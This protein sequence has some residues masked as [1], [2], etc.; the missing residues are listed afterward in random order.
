MLY[1]CT[2]QNIEKITKIIE[3]EVNNYDESC[4][5]KYVGRHI[6]KQ[7]KLQMTKQCEIDIK[8]GQFT[9]EEK[10]KEKEK[11]ILNKVIGNIRMSFINHIG[12]EKIPIPIIQSKIIKLFATLRKKI[13]NLSIDSP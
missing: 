12:S 8:Q 3:E 1:Y 10:L 7:F 13:E 6:S 11:E 4:E 5:K 2:L 9:T